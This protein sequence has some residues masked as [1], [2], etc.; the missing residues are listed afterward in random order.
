MAGACFFLG[1]VRR[2]VTAFDDAAAA[3]MPVRVRISVS[4]TSVRRLI[5]VRNRAIELITDGNH[6]RADQSRAVVA[7]DKAVRREL[8]RIV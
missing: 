2:C 8:L 5:A 4:K 6:F 7:I 1:V 3:L